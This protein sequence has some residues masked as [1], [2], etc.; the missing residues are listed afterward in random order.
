M[1]LTGTD[2]NGD[3][4]RDNGSLGGTQAGGACGD[5]EGA[6]NESAGASRLVLVMLRNQGEDGERGRAAV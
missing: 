4:G 2:E 6:I 5:D 1:V 3:R